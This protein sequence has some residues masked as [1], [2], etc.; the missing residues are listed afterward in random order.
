M[1]DECR[2]ALCS[3]RGPCGGP[4]VLILACK[5]AKMNSLGERRSLISGGKAL[6]AGAGALTG[7]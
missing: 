3:C 6:V 2:N 5:Y 4:D 1:Y 7:V